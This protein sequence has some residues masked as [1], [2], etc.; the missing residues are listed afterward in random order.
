MRTLGWVHR[1]EPFGDAI[2]HHAGLVDPRRDVPQ[3][4]ARWQNGVLNGSGRAVSAGEK[5]ERLGGDVVHI[6][7]SGGGEQREV[8]TLERPSSVDLAKQDRHSLV[9]VF[10]DIQA[11]VDPNR[12]LGLAR[13]HNRIDR[14]GLNSACQPA[15]TLAG[16]LHPF[17][18]GL[19]AT[20]DLQ[21]RRRFFHPGLD[22][23]TALGEHGRN[24]VQR[25]IRASSAHT[26]SGDPAERPVILGLTA[27]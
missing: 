6:P 22:R 8:A 17:Q 5:L 25:E 16:L 23:P 19:C 11:R 4:E 21:A 12:L 15:S 1:Q 26:E 20:S 24:A 3:R 10:G 2:D 7:R 9:R 14:R 18:A 27:E 13:A